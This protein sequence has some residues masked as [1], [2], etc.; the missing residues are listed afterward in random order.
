MICRYREGI[1]KRLGLRC[2]H[3]GS[4]CLSDE[5]VEM[6]SGTL[7]LETLLLWG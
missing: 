4:V 6:A 2:A 5:L 3:P 7:P 1:F